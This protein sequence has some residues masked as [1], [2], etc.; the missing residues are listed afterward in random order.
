MDFTNK[1]TI[2]TTNY[3][4]ILNQVWHFGACSENQKKCP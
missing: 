1:T 3:W 2:E 4:K